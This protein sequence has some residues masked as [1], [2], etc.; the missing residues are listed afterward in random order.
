M[1][2]AD[3]P[4][5]LSQLLLFFLLN[6]LAAASI[7]SSASVFLDF[8]RRVRWYRCGGDRFP[9]VIDVVGSVPGDGVPF[10]NL[11]GADWPGFGLWCWVALGSFDIG[12]HGFADT[13]EEFPAFLDG[14]NDVA[15]GCVPG[16][17]GRSTGG[18]G[19]GSAVGAEGLLGLVRVQWMNA[20][21]VLHQIAWVS[22]GA[23]EPMLVKWLGKVDGGRGMN[24]YRGWV[25][26]RRPGG[27][28]GG[29]GGGWRAGWRR[30]APSGGW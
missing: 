1:A 27:C 7:S 25:L 14:L 13:A 2:S 28:G 29:R 23:V 18:A 26:R 19:R 4:T 10:W 6:I 30:S 24:V 17:A 15:A 8:A 3:A 16:L 20:V 11:E 22:V 21:Q 9:I 12:G 5:L